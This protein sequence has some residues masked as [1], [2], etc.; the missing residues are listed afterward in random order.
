MESRLIKPMQHVH[1]P[2]QED[3]DQATRDS[4]QEHQ[5]VPEAQSI[6]AHARHP[7]STSMSTSTVPADTL[8][9]SPSSFSSSFVSEDPGDDGSI[10]HPGS[11]NAA[12]AAIEAANP[13][14]PLPIAI[15][16]RD[17]NLVRFQDYIREVGVF[18]FCYDSATEECYIEMSETAEH[19]MILRETESLVDRAKNDILALL[20]APATVPDTATTP[21]DATATE[22]NYLTTGSRI[23]SVRSIRA[24]RVK[25]PRG[26]IVQPDISF[27][28]LKFC[29]PAFVAEIAFSQTTADVEK[30]ALEYIKRAAVPLC[31]VRV[32]LI[33]D[34]S[35]PKAENAT[36]SLLAANTNSDEPYWV[37][38]RQPFYDK[39]TETQL[40]GGIDIFASDFLGS[41]DGVPED[42]VRLPPASED[43]APR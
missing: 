43:S 18:R 23:R 38:R 8:S 12:V 30:K 11:Y 21:E 36:V 40:G 13:I 39:S 5:P 4:K 1:K 28:E 15:H 42:L 19:A 24:T 35:Y 22:T 14:D 25:T 34:V 16:L 27:R 26:S 17:T 9:S 29:Y 7:S 32:V 6:E 37:V 41:L 31:R 20:T 33:V 10:D 3:E 2:G